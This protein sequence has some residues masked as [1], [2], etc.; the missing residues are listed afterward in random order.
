MKLRVARHT[1]KLEPIIHFYRD[2]LGLEVLGSFEDHN[3]YNGVFLGL[4][5]AGWHL[6]FTTSAQA[7]QH[8]PDEDDLLVFYQPSVAEYEALRQ[9]FEA[10]N[11]KSIPAIN[12]YWNTNGCTYL[13]SDGY[14]IVIAIAGNY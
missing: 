3:G 5:D 13:D 12:P 9:K 1:A 6:E 7:P 10:H 4:K 8:E 2:L 11:I 14:R